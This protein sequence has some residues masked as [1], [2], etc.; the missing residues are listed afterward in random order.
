MTAHLQPI[1]C[2]Y[3]Y[4]SVVQFSSRVLKLKLFKFVKIYEPTQFIINDVALQNWFCSLAIC[5]DNTCIIQNL[6]LRLD[7]KL[8]IVLLRGTMS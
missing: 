7:R 4:F 1:R 3:M 2:Q 8:L 6:L 5:V